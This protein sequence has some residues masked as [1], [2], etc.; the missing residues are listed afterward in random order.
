MLGDR[1]WVFNLLATYLAIMSLAATAYIVTKLKFALKPMPTLRN[2]AVGALGFTALFTLLNMV[3]ADANIF[4]G[5]LEFAGGKN[6]DIPLGAMPV[7]VHR[8]Y[9]DDGRLSCRCTSGVSHRFH[10]GRASRWSQYAL[11]IC[12][13]TI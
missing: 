12:A 11:L 10:W 8:A 7:E 6:T 4:P 13:P 3:P 5:A 9:R 1:A 2:M